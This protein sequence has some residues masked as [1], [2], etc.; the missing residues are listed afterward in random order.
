VEIPGWIQFV[1]LLEQ[2]LITI[3]HWVGNPGL[4][5][6]IFTFGVKLLTL[7]LTMK[8]FK[9][10]RE[11]QRVQPL[12]KEIAKRYK[13]DKA[14]QQAETMRVY[15]AHGVNPMGGCLPM[16]V[17]LPIF[18]ALYQALT[19]LVGGVGN[20]TPSTVDPIE[21]LAFQQAFLWV[22][23]LAKA[24]PFYIWPVLSGIFQFI[25]QRMSMPYGY[26]KSA[27]P[28]QAMMNRI[29]QFMP[30]YLVVI[31]L[32]FPAGVV[33]YWTFSGI[34]TAM[35]TFLINGFGSLS[36]VPGLT[37]L[38]KRPLPPPDP[39]I[40][41]EMEEIDARAEAERKG[42][43]AR[44]AGATANRTAAYLENRR[45]IPATGPDGKPRRKSFME[46]MMEQAVEAQERQQALAAEQAAQARGS[47]TGETQRLPETDSRG[48]AAHGNGHD[49]DEGATTTALPRKRKNKR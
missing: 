28:Q 8:S 32:S 4:A 17:Q 40:I 31:Y 36:E 22:P 30:I 44:P 10:T 41:A 15:S 42:G 12:I 11:M 19:S 48:F 47:E 6:I 13:D 35:Q 26:S 3:N 18:F 37:W 9:S 34:F 25:Q 38:P 2:I 49:A 39:A 5:I 27:D 7:P 33:I 20:V 23:N 43:A 24:D 14:K 29:M 21:Q 16:L 45:A 46:K 1:Q